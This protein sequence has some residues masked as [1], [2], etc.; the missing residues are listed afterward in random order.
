M[1]GDYDG[2]GARVPAVYRESA[3]LWAV[4]GVTRLY[5]GAAGD[6]PVPADY[7]GNSSDDTGIFRESSGLWAIRGVS[8]V[9][10]GSS[11]D[12]PVTR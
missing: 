10:F 3:G 5:F 11:G 4:R 9:Y 8:R 2:S 7:D 12:I 6:R 1:P